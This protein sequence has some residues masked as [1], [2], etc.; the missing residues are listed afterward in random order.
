MGD[1][2]KKEPLAARMRPRN[3][4]EFVGQKDIVGDGT[5]LR[6]AIEQGAAGSLIFHGPAGCGK[7]TL[8]EIIVRHVRAHVEHVSAVSAKVS[9]LRNIITTAQSRWKKEN[10][11]TIVIVDEIHRFTK[12]Q[13]D[14]LLPPVEDGTI[15]MIGLTTENPYFSVVRGLVSRSQVYRLSPLAED[16]VKDIIDRALADA[17]YGYGKR[18]IRIAPDAREYLASIAGGDA[19]RALNA[20]ELAATTKKRKERV[21][22]I[23]IEHAVQQRALQ[24]DR[25]GD[26]HYDT[27]SAF[28]KSMRGSDPDAA[29][30]WMY[31]ML[32]AGEQPEFIV[33]RMII[34]ASEDIGNADPHALMVTVS[35][36]YALQYVGLPEAE[37]ALSQAATYLAAAPKSDAVKR[38]MK[39]VKADLARYGQ[40]AVPNHLRN[41]PIPEMK[42]EGASV[43]YKDPHHSEG[44]V[45]L[46]QYMPERLARRTYYEPTEQGFE[47]EV[48]KRVDA[49]R[50]LTKSNT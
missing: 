20:L 36:G 33:R 32:A 49:A 4:N 35:A 29:L 38:A 8:A 5:V 50:V 22:R 27:I 39:G 26:E 42:R 17:K 7:T 41:A 48:K 9:D 1:D 3:L 25:A 31:K 16:N 11:R 28:I 2:I 43:G 34:F 15:T 45:V 13:Q 37:Y 12:T 18:G 19:R 24:Y 6:N 30:F 23:D 40:L 14:V 46:Q 21:T 44:H 10:K 47:R